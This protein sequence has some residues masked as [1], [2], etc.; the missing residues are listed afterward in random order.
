MASLLAILGYLL[1]FLLFIAGIPALMWWA[2]GRPLFWVP[3]LLPAAIAAVL[4]V[5]GLAI[6][7]RAIIYMKKVGE[8]NPFD[9]YGHEV[10]PRT[11]HLMTSGPYRRSRNPMLLGVYI[12]DL[13][14][15]LWLLSWW[16]LAIFAAEALLLTLQV[17]SEEKR[18]ETDFG[19]EYLAY[20]RR[21][22]RY[23]FDSTR[24]FSIFVR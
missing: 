24:F 1:G 18:L 22:P 3:S 2:S 13:G 5:L 14:L 17:R 19:E 8:G 16:P 10:A 12:Y 9:A 21:V 23:L 7:I 15:M 4:I 11:R 20:K 6:S